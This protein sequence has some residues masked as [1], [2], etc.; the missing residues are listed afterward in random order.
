LFYVAADGRVMAVAISYEPLRVG[1]STP[2]FPA[3]R[4]FASR[5][6]TGNRHSAPWDVRPD[7]QQFLIAAPVEAG[8]SSQFTVVLNWQTGLTR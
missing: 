6:S 3:P 8:A 2:L 7:G 4:G 1:E 5:D